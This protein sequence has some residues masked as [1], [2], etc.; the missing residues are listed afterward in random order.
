MQSQLVAMISI[1][2]F[3]I[4]KL[5]FPTHSSLI[6]KDHMYRYQT[7]ILVYAV[8]TAFVISC[9]IHKVVSCKPIVGLRQNTSS[10]LGQQAIRLSL[11]D[12]KNVSDH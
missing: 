1:A 10:A 5:E 7:R 8:M 12:V 6:Q 9:T 3:V 11:I 2:F 4:G